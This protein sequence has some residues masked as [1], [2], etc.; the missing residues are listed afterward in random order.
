MFINRATFSA[1]YQC[2]FSSFQRVFFPLSVSSTIYS[3]SSSSSEDNE[4]NYEVPVVPG[5]FTPPI[6]RTNDD[7]PIDSVY[8]DAERN[9]AGHDNEEEYD[10]YMEGHGSRNDADD[11]ENIENNEERN[12]EDDNGEER[13]S[14]VP[15]AQTTFTRGRQSRGALGSDV[16]VKSE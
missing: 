10:E 9:M 11:R 12:N 8:A 16:I 5:L 6:D 7:V 1:C 13:S 14:R 15:P 4:F 3:M 2:V